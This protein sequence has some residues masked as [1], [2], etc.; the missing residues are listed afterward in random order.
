MGRLFK[1]ILQLVLTLFVIAFFTTAW[2]VFDGLTDLGEKSDAVLVT[3]SSSEDATL[4]QMEPLL[5]KA[6]KIYREGDSSFVII[7]GGASEGKWVDY[8][9]Q[10]GVPANAILKLPVSALNTEQV[11]TAAGTL[12]KDNNLESVMIVTEYYH[13][14]RAKLALNHE[15]INSIQKAHIGELKKEDAMAIA[16]EIVGLYDFVGRVYVLPTV[17]NLFN[18]AKTDA[19]KAATDA[20]TKVDGGLDKISK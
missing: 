14:T 2:V 11:A 10:K 18:K 13:M 20:K 3:M 8:L 1:F 16:H 9:Q 19:D 6:A 15:G 4:E 17:E 7:G 5:D 12:L